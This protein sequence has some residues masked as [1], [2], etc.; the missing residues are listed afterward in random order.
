MTDLERIKGL[1]QYIASKERSLGR[2]EDIWGKGVRSGSASAD[3][4]ID[5]AALDRAVRELAKL[6][7]KQ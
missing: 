1:K 4:A 7:A 5:R 2:S 3:L 6:E